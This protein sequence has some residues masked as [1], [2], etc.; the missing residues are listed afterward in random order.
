MARA[1]VAARIP[2]FTPYALRHRRTSLWHGQGVPVK[3][4]MARTGHAKATTTLDVYSHVLIDKTELT[5]TQ[6]LSRCGPGVVND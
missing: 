6:L 3:E 5:A 1:C 4:L 2:H